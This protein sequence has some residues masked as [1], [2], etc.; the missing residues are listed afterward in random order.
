GSLPMDNHSSKTT[1]NHPSDGLPFQGKVPIVIDSAKVRVESLEVR[2]RS[3]RE[4]ARETKAQKYQ[5]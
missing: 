4:G 5:K 2:G 1:N 3:C